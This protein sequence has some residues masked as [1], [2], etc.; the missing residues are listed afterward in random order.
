ML[1]LR[2]GVPQPPPE[3]CRTSVSVCGSFTLEFFLLTG[4]IFSSDGSPW[5]PGEPFLTLEV[6]SDRRRPAGQT[7]N[8]TGSC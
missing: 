6:K 2:G 5:V 4:Q 8:L 3:P 7:F 1:C